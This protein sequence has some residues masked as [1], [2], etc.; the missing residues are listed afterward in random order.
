MGCLCSASAIK[1]LV[2]GEKLSLSEWIKDKL[3]AGGA[4]LYR[5][6]ECSVR[7]IRNIRTTKFF[8][9]IILIGYG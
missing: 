7:G 6:S 1:A 3:L 4:M 8:H 2:V 5:E 9:M